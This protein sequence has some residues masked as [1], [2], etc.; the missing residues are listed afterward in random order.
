[1]DK[2]PTR[3]G[4]VGLIPREVHVILTADQVKMLQEIITYWVPGRGNVDRLRAL[5]IRTILGEADRA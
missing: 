1:M 2:Y 4:V 3:I 5:T